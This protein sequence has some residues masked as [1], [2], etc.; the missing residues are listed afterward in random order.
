[1]PKYLG[2]IWILNVLVAAGCSQSNGSDNTSNKATST[3]IVATADCDDCPNKEPATHPPVTTGSSSGGTFLNLDYANWKQFKVGTLVR[4]K[5][6]TTTIHGPQIVTS[7]NTFQLTG[8]SE[9]SIEVTRQNTTDR[10]DGTPIKVNPGTSF[11]YAKQFPIPA[12]MSAEDFAKPS[13]KAKKTGEEEIVILGKKYKTTVY[14]WVDA[15]EAGPMDVTAWICDELP[16]RIAKQTMKQPQ[17]NT[18]I[19]EISEIVIK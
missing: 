14:Q 2:I 17:T 10:G 1:M 16:G 13:L 6:T 18:T 15:T 8:V 9:H 4:R 19:E 5:S 3:A 7:V 11:K 12:G